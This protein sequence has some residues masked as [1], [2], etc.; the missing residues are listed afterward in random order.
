M[1]QADERHLLLEHNEEVLPHGDAGERK[2]PEAQSL[3]EP[4]S[5]TATP[6]K[7]DE[8]PHN[9]PLRPFETSEHVWPFSRYRDIFY[10]E[11][12][13]EPKLEMKEETKR[14][15][16]AGDQ[17][18]KGD[19]KDEG[20]A[21]LSAEEA[22]TEKKEEGYAEKTPVAVPARAPEKEIIPVPLTKGD[23]KLVVLACVMLLVILL[24][25]G[26]MYSNGRL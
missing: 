10:G 21:H 23:E 25:L 16:F 20:A 8:I 9:L 2:V 3:I 18:Q 11:S 7:K 26:Y 1:P 15:D 5:E 19:V 12:E 24:L 13:P 6:R 4:S 17:A 14:G 22:K